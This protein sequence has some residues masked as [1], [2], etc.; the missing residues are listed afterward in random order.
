MNKK[1]SNLHLFS[2]FSYCRK[3]K[4][5][6]FVIFKFF[7]LFFYKLYGYLSW[8]LF[9]EIILCF[10]I[11]FDYKKKI[12]QIEKVKKLFKKIY[13]YKHLFSI[14]R[15][16]GGREKICFLMPHSNCFIFF[17]FYTKFQVSKSKCSFSCSMNISDDLK[18][19]IFHR[20]DIIF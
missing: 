17:L 8:D 13:L 11:P 9:C 20:F 6:F 19:L 2:C 5:F 18:T 1:N 4:M 12:K 3:K 10:E 16:W 14:L 15:V 7:P